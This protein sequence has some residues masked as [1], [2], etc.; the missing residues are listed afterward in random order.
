[1]KI[2]EGLKSLKRQPY[3]SV[4]TI[5]VFDG[6]H[7]GHR[8]II[9]KAV[10]AAHKAG[11][12]SVAVTFDPHPVKVLK[13]D[14]CIPSLISLKHRI[15]LIEE[16]GI[17]TLVVVKF[18]KPF[19]RMS[20]EEFTKDILIDKLRMRSIFVGDN[21]YFGRGG[22]GGA[23]LLQKMSHLYGFKVFAVKPVKLMGHVASSSLI[24]K[25]MLRGDL[26][27]ASKLLGRSVSVLGTV[28]EGAGIAKGLGYP[29]ANVN[30]HHEAIPPRGV[31]AV[32]MQF[33][34]KRF[35][36]ILNIGFR[37]TFY[38]PR[39]LEPTIEVHIFGYKG[40][41]Y[42][43]D[44]EVQFVKKIRDERKFETADNLVRQINDDVVMARAI[45]KAKK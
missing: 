29:T 21:F 13:A 12:A 14:H 25:F 10:A 32:R 7:I 15:R 37:P 11:L 41:L 24:R 1:M 35:N 28:V 31:Y 22:R 33:G 40:N 42:N 23:G 4:V 6:L 2:V 39:D 38:S 16:L 34:K 20:P 43:K 3:D 9:K 5:G 17:D 27:K 26:R 45:L 19:S 36:G 44:I 30:P 18:T 8:H